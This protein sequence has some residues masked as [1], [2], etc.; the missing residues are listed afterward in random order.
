M[1]QKSLKDAIR[2]VE[3]EIE[4]KAWSEK[5]AIYGNKFNAQKFYELSRFWPNFWAVMWLLW[6][7]WLILALK[8]VPWKIVLFGW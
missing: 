2:D 4:D 6:P 1:K 5:K 3:K 8:Y 7:L